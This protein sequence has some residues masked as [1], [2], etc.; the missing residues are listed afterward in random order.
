ML[1]AD[2]DAGIANGIEDEVEA[3][4]GSSVFDAF[5]VDKPT[6]YIVL[7]STTTSST[8][9]FATITVKAE[10]RNVDSDGAVDPANDADGPTRGFLA[11]VG[12]TMMEKGGGDTGEGLKFEA[13]SKT[14]GKVTR[15]EFILPLEDET[16]TLIHDM[17]IELEDFGFPSSIRTSSVAVTTNSGTAE[18]DND[19]TFTPE[20]VAISGEKLL[21]SMGDITEDTSGIQDKRS[22]VY[23]LGG[24]GH[25]ITVVIRT[26]AGI[27]N[28]TESKSYK[29]QV[30]FG[31]NKFEDV[32]GLFV[33]RVVGLDEED[34][35][36]GDKIT[37]TG[38]GYKNG[39]T[40]T[41]WRDE[42]TPVMW[43]NRYRHER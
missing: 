27:S 10:D 25:V 33:P 26:T 41:F 9:D 15:Y 17:V 4:L 31:E 37:V 11:I 32:E 40:V 5:E 36:R 16:N 2:G 29:A 18:T 8:G 35:G 7:Y 23:L 21:L 13:T 28:P 30:V 1:T 38:K 6:G 12:T 22:G 39:T 14:P 34:G 20:D 3:A 43:D 42:M 24:S 19:F